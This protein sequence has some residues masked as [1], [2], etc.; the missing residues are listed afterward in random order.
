MIEKHPVSDRAE[1]LKR[2]A[3][4]LTA[5][6]IGA[7]AGVDKFKT[8]LGL[9]AEKTGAIL[10]AGDNPAMRR[11]RWLESAV[12]AA[13]REEHPDWEVRP[14]GLY[15]RDPDL[16]LG[17]TPDFVAITDEPGITNIQAKVV[18]RPTFEREWTAGPPLSYQLQTTCEAMLM[19]AQRSIVAALVIDTY[20]AD[21]VL[22]P[23]PRHATAE[24]AIRQVAQDFWDAVREGRAP[25]ADYGQDREV[26]EALHPTS[27]AEPVLDLTGDNELAVLLPELVALKAGIKTDSKRVGEIETAIRA[28]LGDAERATLPGWSVSWKS[29]HRKET[30]VKA[31]DYRVLRVR[32]LN[33]KEEAA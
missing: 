18:S 21:L 11:G 4:D 3:L 30:V 26:I 8:R 33:E 20:N 27:V 22:F 7:A 14:V 23:L 16:R 15:Y 28:K 13:I 19:D 24:R 5:S 17:G 31:S 32:D 9:Y 29:Q 10:P 25:P 2:R 6:D 12:L 1:W